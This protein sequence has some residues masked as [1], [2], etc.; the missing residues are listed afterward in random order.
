MRK[1][2]DRQEYQVMIVANKFQAGFD[3]LKLVVFFT[4]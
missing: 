3:Q 2:F 1:V 4:W